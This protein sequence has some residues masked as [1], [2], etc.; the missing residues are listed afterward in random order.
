MSTTDND[1]ER[2]KANLEAAMQAYIVAQYG[3]DHWLG[4]YVLSAVVLDMSS[5]GGPD[6][7]HYFHDSRGPSHSIRGLTIEQDE[8]LVDLRIEE[9]NDAEGDA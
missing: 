8:W 6:T 7:T 2:T 3:P 9:K 5:G 4:D 1:I